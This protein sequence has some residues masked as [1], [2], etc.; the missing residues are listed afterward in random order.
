MLPL[1]AQEEA[2]HRGLLGGGGHAGTTPGPL[3][4]GEASPD[5][6]RRP[7]RRRVPSGGP[8]R[9]GGARAR[10]R[11]SAGRCLGGARER[12]GPSRPSGDAAPGPAPR[13]WRGESPSPGPE[14]S[15]RHGCPGAE[16]SGPVPSPQRPA[17]IF[18]RRHRRQRQRACASAAG[19]AGTVEDKGRPRPA[20][21]CKVGALPPCTAR[22][23][24]GY[25]SQENAKIYHKKENVEIKMM[26][27]V[28]ESGSVGR[29]LGI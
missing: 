4:L 22:R 2:P 25:R 20:P 18:L 1:R 9:P 21:G 27:I 24:A 23:S 13:P 7:A 17:A 8:V 6:A 11:G 14:R 26:A 12:R 28:W 15:G 5:P 19:N 29:G 16:R 3:S 10:R